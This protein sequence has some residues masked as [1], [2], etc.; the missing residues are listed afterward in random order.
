MI[1]IVA[2]G[3]IFIMFHIYQCVCVCRMAKIRSVSNVE[4][5]NAVLLTVI[6]VLYI[7]SPELTCLL[8]VN[9]SL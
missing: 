4:V 7:R 9:L 5:Y 8:V 1:T 3:N 2:L 6:P